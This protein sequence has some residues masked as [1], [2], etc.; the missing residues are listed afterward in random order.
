M[1]I[2]TI[3]PIV[4][5]AIIADAAS[6]AIALSKGAQESNPL[7]REP[8][9]F[10]GFVGPLVKPF[11]VYIGLLILLRWQAQIHWVQEAFIGLLVVAL[12]FALGKIHAATEN[13]SL[14]YLNF[15]PSNT[16]RHVLGVRSGIGHLVFNGIYFGLLWALIVI[17]FVN[18]QV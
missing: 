14:A 6:T 10:L 12:A 15:S 17:N 18:V 4:V 1:T 2:Y 8:R 11:L 9:G 5:F 3:L 13:V 7:M 16:L